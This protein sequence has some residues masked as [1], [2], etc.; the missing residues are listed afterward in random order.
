MGTEDK[1]IG[2]CFIKSVKRYFKK[3]ASDSTKTPKLTAKQK[4]EAGKARSAKLKAERAKKAASAK[5]EAETRAK[6]KLKKPKAVSP[7]VKQ[8]ATPSLK[9]KV[10]PSLKQ[11]VTPSLKQKVTPSLKQKVTGKAASRGYLRDSSGKKVKSGSGYVRT[12]YPDTPTSKSLRGKNVAPKDRAALVKK[13]RAAKAHEK[14][15]AE[16]RKQGLFA[17]GGLVKPRRAT[18]PKSAAKSTKSNKVVKP[19]SKGYV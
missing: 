13:M 3:G 10:T 8:K 4:F 1:G 9:Q 7:T 2:S 19:R 15:L 18:K 5:K 14:R 11:K 17:K 6:N 12:T 16:L